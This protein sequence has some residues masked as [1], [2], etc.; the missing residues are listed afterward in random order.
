MKVEAECHKC[1]VVDHLG[2]L[3]G[4]CSNMVDGERRKDMADMYC[5]L[6]PLPSG[7]CV[8][9]ET[10]ESY[11]KRVG[12]TA[13][14][15]L[16]TETAHLDFVENVIIVYKKFKEIVS[17]VFKSDQLF[18]STLDKAFTSIINHKGSSRNNCR[19]PEL[20]LP[21]SL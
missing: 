14:S 5:L 2:M 9:A 17:S 4:E 7:L 13:V 10:F 21:I 6:R 11:V 20:V 12:L 1:L 8:L 3:H 16:K 18:L 15:N 19:S